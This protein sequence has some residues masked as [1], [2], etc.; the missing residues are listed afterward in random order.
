MRDSPIRW[1][2][3]S[4]REDGDVDLVVLMAEGAPIVE[5]TDLAL[6]APWA[7]IIERAW[8]LAFEKGR[9]PHDCCEPQSCPECEL[10]RRHKEALFE[11]AGRR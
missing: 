11:H 10:D 8:D 6:A 7:T 4:Q 2:Y 5:R 9:V 3:V 1:A